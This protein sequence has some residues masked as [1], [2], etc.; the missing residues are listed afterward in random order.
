[1]TVISKT[2]G[3]LTL[4]SCIRDIHKNALIKANIATQKA[5]ADTFVANSLATQRTNRL[6]SKDTERKNWLARKNFLMCPNEAMASI[7]GYVGGF[8]DGAVNYIPQLALSVV[9]IALN[10]KHKVLAN[11][12]A[13]A[14]GILEGSD[15]IN[16]SLS[17]G[18]K[19]D[20][21]KMK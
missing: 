1:M 7:K 3:V 17:I 8:F 16:N 4:V 6:S 20:Y 12:S 5:S 11:L 13:I 18:Q 14:L 15:F 19:N 21:L 10:S 2:A 9:A